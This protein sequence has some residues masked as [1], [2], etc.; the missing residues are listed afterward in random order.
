MPRIK[1]LKQVF[2]PVPRLGI[3]ENHSPPSAADENSFMTIVILG[4]QL[5][6]VCNEEQQAEVRIP[7]VG[8]LLQRERG[9]Y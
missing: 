4:C 7:D 3:L 6:A 9:G 1:L 8:E 2:D 5:G